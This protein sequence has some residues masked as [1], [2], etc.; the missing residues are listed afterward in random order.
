MSTEYRIEY[1]IQR[2]TDD[3]PENFIEIGFGSSGTHHD[4]DAATYAIESSVPR[5]EWETEGDMPDPSDVVADI[6]AAK[7]EDR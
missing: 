4:L 1:S 6:E 2:A 7:E 5:G 3:D